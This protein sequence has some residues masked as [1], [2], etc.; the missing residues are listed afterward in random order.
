MSD[1]RDGAWYDDMP[2]LICSRPLLEMTLYRRLADHPSLR[3]LQKHEVLGLHLDQRGQQVTGVR[4]R[5]RG[6]LDSV[7]AELAAD[8]V[9]DASGRGSHAPQWLASLGYIPPRETTINA[10]AGYTSRIYRRPADFDGSW[11]MMRIRRTPPHDTRGGYI[12]PLEGDRWLVTLIGMGRDYPPTDEAGFLAFARSL[13]S[14]RLYKAI[15]VAEPLTK[16]Y[17]YRL[18]ESRLRHYDQL[19]RY[20][21]GFLV[22]GDAACA[23]SPV[24]AQGMTA[25]VTGAHA[26]ADC[27]AEQR[28]RGDLFGLAQTFQK[29]LRQTTSSI[30]QLVTEDD[31][32]WPATE[33]AENVIPTRQRVPNHRLNPAPAPTSYNIAYL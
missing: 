6:G 1:L 25:A 23:L 31:L 4:L 19:P 15:E 28:R 9:V 12:L 3:L 11:Q 26:L 5:R 16:V 22:C 29:Q 21:E 8:L 2:S 24:H 33:V 7:G 17:G 10:F 27:L 18:T 14:P 30:W 13:S 32:R 20:L